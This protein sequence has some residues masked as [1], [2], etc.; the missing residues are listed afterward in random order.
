MKH[1]PGPWKGG[2][3]K[4]YTESNEPRWVVYASSKQHGKGICRVVN[5]N[6]HV[7]SYQEADANAKL[8]AE[9]PNMLE[10]LKEV[11]ERLDG[12]D[13]LLRHKD[14]NDTL[15]CVIRAHAAIKAATS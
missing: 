1:T 4:S 2:S 13:R 15:S 10:A 11:T 3:G 14:T 5:Y 12:I 6:K 7:K 9:A 8:I